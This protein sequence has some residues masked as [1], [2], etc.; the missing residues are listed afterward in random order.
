MMAWK[1]K[2][3]KDRDEKVKQKE[4]KATEG[5][6]FKPEINKRSERLVK[7][8]KRVPIQEREI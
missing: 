5:Y 4:Q 3:E 1:S 7:N 2:L 6:T 8:Q